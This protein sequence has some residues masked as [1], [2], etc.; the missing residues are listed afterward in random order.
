MPVR[1][2]VG[3]PGVP[4]RVGVLEPDGVAVVAVVQRSTVLLTVAMVDPVVKLT[5]ASVIETWSPLQ[6]MSDWATV[7]A[8]SP[9]SGSPLSLTSSM[10][11]SKAGKPSF[12]R[13]VMS[14]K[15][16]S[17]WLTGSQTSKVEVF[18][19]NSRDAPAPGATHVPCAKARAG[20][21]GR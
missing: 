19:Q 21:C 6:K 17:A 20:I 9:L 16:Q 10:K 1:V 12:S 3:V 7:E 13:P 4:V 5:T 14:V 2:G 15:V 8:A 11:R 18:T